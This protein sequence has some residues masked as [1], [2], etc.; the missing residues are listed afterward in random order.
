VPIVPPEDAVLLRVLDERLGEAAR[1]AGDRLAC[2][3]GCTSCCVG[4]F[5]ITPLDAARLGDG[6]RALRGADPDRAA[7]VE[8]RA[9]F[10]AEA[11]REGFP[12]D[13]DAGV[14]A[15]DD[16][17][18][19][20]FLARHGA[21]PCPALDPDAGTCD[22]YAHR[23]VSCRTYGPPVRLGGQDLPPCRLCFVDA[24]DEDVARCRVEPD[25]DGIEDVVLERLGRGDRSTLVAFALVAAG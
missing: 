23:P 1:R 11:F 4:P 13:A 16:D 15:D 7:R 14:L 12:G 19:E 25:P 5:P 8:A 22:L 9:R 17:E 18:E 20:A 3:P 21:V 10:T 2:R 6:L 24:S